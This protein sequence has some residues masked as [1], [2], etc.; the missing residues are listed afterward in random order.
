[1]KQEIRIAIAILLAMMSTAALAA[2]YSWN[3][4]HAKVLP[5]GELEW[6]PEPFE[7]K[8]GPDVRYID[9]EEGDDNAA[10]T[11]AAPWKHHPWDA[12]ATGKAALATGPMTYVFKGGVIYRGQLVADNS[13]RAGEPIRLTR[14]PD[15]GDGPAMLWGSMRLPQSGWKK[16]AASDLPKYMPTDGKIWFLDTTGLSFDPK[17]IDNF[18]QPADPDFEVFSVF[19]VEGDT[20]K[21]L[22][23][24]RDPDWQPGNPNFPLDYWHSWDGFFK[25]EGDERVGRGGQD[26][27]LKGKPEDF[28]E[29]GYL[30]S[31]WKGN[32]G[33]PCWNPIKKGD[34]S[35]THGTLLPTPW[36]VG[37][38]TRYM[39]E[40]V[41]AY[42][43]APGEFYFARSGEHKGKLYLRLPDDS[44]PNGKILEVPAMQDIIAIR[45]KSH[46]EISGLQFAFNRVHYVGDQF[47]M[48]ISNPACVRIGGDC[49]DI[50]VSNNVFMQVITAVTA[51]PSP[52]ERL[53]GLHAQGLLPWA[54]GDFLDNIHVTDND[55]QHCERE[56]IVVYSGSGGGAGAGRLGH[57]EI[58]RNRIYHVGFR[59]GMWRYSAIPAI[60]LHYPQTGEIAGN[61][62][63][64]SWGTAIM[65]HGGK[66]GGDKEA[67]LTRIMVH[68]NKVENTVL[69]VNDYGAISLWQG[70]PIFAYNNISGNCVGHAPDRALDSP[71][72]NVG[73][74]YYIDGGYKIYTFNNISWGRSND[75]TDPYRNN[76]TYFMVF[77][78]LNPVVNN[79]FYRAY[80][81]IAG[82]SGNRNDII[83][84]IVADIKTSFIAS[85]RMGDPSLA[86][87]GDT[88]EMGLRGVPSLAYANNLLAGKAEAGTLYSPNRRA[89]EGGAVDKQ[90]SAATAEEFS[91]QMQEF[92]IRYGKLGWQ[93]EETPLVDPDDGDYRP[94][95][96]SRAIDN[97]AQYFIPWSLY[98]TVGEWHFNQNLAK[99]NVATDYHYY[100]T[101]EYIQRKMYE[102]IPT[103]DILFNQ[104]DA[105]S[106]V[107]SQSENWAPGA[108]T[109]DGNRR[110]VV[111]DKSIKADFK[112]DLKAWIAQPQVSKKDIPGEPWTIDGD[113]AIFPGKLRKTLDFDK[114][115]ILVDTIIRIDQGQQGGTIAGK[116]DGKTGY[117]LYVNEN[118]HVAFSLMSDGKGGA[119]VTSQ[120]LNDGK[121]HHILAEVDR[122]IGKANIY[123]DGQASNDGLI[124][125]AP[126]ASLSNQADFIVG[127]GV[128]GAIDFLRVCQG[129]LADA[130][131]SIDELYEWQTNGPVTRDFCGNKPVGRRDIGAVERL[132]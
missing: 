98:A 16:A 83:G 23:V 50:R 117:R 2:D 35:P 75:P 30:A 124:E 54:P 20:I 56:A 65:V 48:Q 53:T 68:H 40:N 93:T 14:D 81:G 33:T 116:F 110:G 94:K 49:Q 21:R 78:F 90:I 125:I 61:M 109:L 108:L 36:I 113:Y 96:G 70:G 38:G 88:G 28:F 86:G 57:A 73:Y 84:N 34:Y 130:K 39:V 91:K 15:W 43:D 42:L 72:K 52:D 132:D 63:D 118:G 25:G 60:N 128:K 26:D 67:P 46:I 87:G 44:D 6:A 127:E 120:A 51:F 32:M 74:P 111:T 123:V 10:G 115:N 19:Q 121:W 71:W 13:G 99:P 45:D 37:D 101:Q 27:D 1:M 119:I 64:T 105:D 102:Y 104:A 66:H 85:N 107:E 31:Q 80:K 129:T 103:F 79:T 131:T 62:I 77:G 7:Y 82:S 24:A 41:P 126:D 106:Y 97:G 5:Q 100:M 59:Q 22:H 29:G 58:L 69:A 11:K 4:P 89:I 47:L 8:A 17:W 12:N 3:Q 9:Y 122:T 95:S 92:P 76:G 18:A 112:V 114:T 55:I